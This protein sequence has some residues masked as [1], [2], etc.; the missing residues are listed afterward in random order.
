MKRPAKK[1]SEKKLSKNVS[2]FIKTQILLFIL[3]SAVLFIAS[4]VVYTSTLGSNTYFY[5]TALSLALMSFVGGYY[6]GY[7]I[8]KNGLLISLVYCLP[9]NVIVLFISSAVNKFK[10]DLTI[11][12]SFAILII[13]SMLGGVLSVNTKI[14]TKR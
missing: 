8:H 13:C 7:K 6:S 11:L 10:I 9:M 1:K 2:V 12:I 5:I 4:L 3:Y 14:K